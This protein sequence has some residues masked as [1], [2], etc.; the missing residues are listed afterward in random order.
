MDPIFWIPIGM[1]LVIAVAGVFY[2]YWQGESR[3]RED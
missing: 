1:I 3:K 2:A